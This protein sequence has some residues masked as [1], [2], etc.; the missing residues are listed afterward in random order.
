MKTIRSLLIAAAVIFAGPALAGPGPAVKAS[1]KTDAGY[2]APP[3]PGPA[4]KSG[5]K[6]DAGYQAPKPK[7]D[8]RVS[9]VYR[10][11]YYAPHATVPSWTE[12]FHNLVPDVAINKILNDTYV[13]R[14]PDTGFWVGLI[15]GPG[16]AGCAAGDTMTSHAGWA[17]NATYSNA[18]RVA[19]SPGAVS[20]KS[21]SNTSTPAVFNINGTATIGGAFMV[22]GS[23]GTADTKSGTGGT[24]RSCGAFSTGDKAVSNGGTLTVTITA[25]GS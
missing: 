7:A 13:T 20:A 8:V 22:S 17:E 10:L 2:Q 24:I 12:D 25:T 1:S 3:N 19:W 21:T 23:A 4:V 16:A 15:T 14:A 11:A 6:S 18:T 9:H 5:V